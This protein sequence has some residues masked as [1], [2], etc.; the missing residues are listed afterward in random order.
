MEKK[1]KFIHRL[2]SKYRL[3]IMNDATYEE[4]ASMTLTK[5]NVFILVS[6]LIVFF[7]GIMAFLLSTTPL[8]EYVPGCVDK[9]QVRILLELAHKVDSLEKVQQAHSSVVDNRIRL[10]ND[11]PDTAMAVNTFGSSDSA[12]HHAELH[13]SPQE[14][15]LREEIKPEQDYSLDREKKSTGDILFAPFFSPLHGLVSARFDPLVNHPATD[16]V[17]GTDQT[18]KATLGGTVILASWTPETGHVIA[19][20]H[21]QNLVSIYKHNSVLLKKVGNFV[22]AG[23]AIAIVGN[24][25]ELSTGPHLHFELWYKGLA[26]NAEDY[27][28][29]K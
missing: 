18:V 27:I 24:S 17:A 12:H 19:L 16:I 22:D 29:F 15:E 11:N 1:K 9:D 3:V 6:S 28:V 20:Q 13:A 5:L 26:V 25:G 7:V 21:D 2:R 10:L 8:K 4:K 14:L 23:E